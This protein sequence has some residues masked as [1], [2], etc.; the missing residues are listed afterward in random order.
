[1]GG[2]VQGAPAPAATEIRLAVQFGIVYLPLLVM[3]EQRLVEAAALRAG[4]PAPTV[5]WLQFSGG[6]AMNDAVISGSLDFGA[7]G[8][9]PILTAWDRTRG[10]LGIKAVAPLASTP[11]LLLS[12]R[13]GVTTLRDFGSEDRIAVPAAKVS[14]QAIMLQMAAEQVFG[15]NQFGRLDSLTVSLD[16]PDAT[17]ALIGGRAGITA[18]FSNPPFQQEELTHAGIHQVQSSYDTLGGP[19]SSAMLYATSRFRDA[20]PHWVSAVIAALESA[21]AFIAAN[22]REAAE[23]YVKSQKSK[24]SV[25]FIEQLLRDPR[26]HFTTEPQGIMAFAKFQ[27]HT[28]QIASVPADWHEVFFP[29]LTARTAI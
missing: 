26:N 14:F 4:L 5:R 22:P 29:E 10:N 6:A 28:R 18:H 24:L 11:S 16:H 25:D 19:H 9:P 20:N 8:I 7:A 2:R 15:P 12:N 23:L 3:Q 13:P 21:D 17:A 27:H 1:M